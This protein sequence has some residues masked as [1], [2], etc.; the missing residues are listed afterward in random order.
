[1]IANVITVSRVLFSLLSFVFAPFSVPFTVLYLLCGVSDVLDGFL[2]RKLHTVSETGAVLDSV[3]DLLFAVVCAVKILPVLHIPLWIW[4]WT[5]LIAAVKVTCIAIASRKTHKLAIAHSF[6]NKLTGLLLFLLP[7]STYIA[8]VKYTAA[9][10]CIAATVT[11]A[12]EI[13]K[14]FGG[15]KNAV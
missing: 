14:I 9:V 4:I 7:L 5:A 3:A 1:M 12:G 13:I 6:G 15:M 8:D 10:V 2:A 11:T